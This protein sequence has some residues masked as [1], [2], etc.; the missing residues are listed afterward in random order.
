MDDILYNVVTLHCTAFPGLLHGKLMLDV[1]KYFFF[2]FD[3]EDT[4]TED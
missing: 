4:N 1:L 2:H 3:L